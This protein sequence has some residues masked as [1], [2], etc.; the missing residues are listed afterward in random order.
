[1]ATSRQGDEHRSLPEASGA[2]VS[3]RWLAGLLLTFCCWHAAFLLGSIIPA[4]PTRE[5]PGN[6]ALALYRLLVVGRQ[7]WN[8][9]NSIPVVHSMDAWLEHEDEKG[10]P[11]TAGCVL[12]GLKTY[13]IPEETRLYQIFWRMTFV[14]D[15][16]PFKEAYLK[17][18]AQ[19]LSAARGSAAREKWTLVLEV[20]YTRT[21]VLSRHDG[22]LS[23][24]ITKT[25]D[26]PLLGGSAQ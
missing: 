10:D 11:I 14:S 1:M 15:G 22:Q 19:L 7:E 20:E 17:K 8:V 24:P 3:S 5:I 6:L 25:F 16:I 2:P 4:P 12:P 13:P 18:A 21:L 9:F 26:L 23:L